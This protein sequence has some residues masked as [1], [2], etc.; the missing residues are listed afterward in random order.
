MT[1]FVTHLL[2]GKC[3]VSHWLGETSL[4]FMLMSIS[5]LMT[6]GRQTFCLQCSVGQPTYWKARSLWNNRGCNGCIM[7]GTIDLISNPILHFALCQY[8]GTRV[9]LDTFTYSQLKNERRKPDLWRPV[10]SPC[11]SA[12]PV[13]CGNRV[14]TEKAT[15]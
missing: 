3:F 12:L 13:P 6:S 5:F 8:K 11:R 7:N 9:R 4:K 1:T 15:Q 14:E 2:N 10:S